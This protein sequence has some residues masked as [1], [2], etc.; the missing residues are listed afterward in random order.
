MINL[1]I[2][3]HSGGEYEVTVEEYDAVQVNADLNNNEINTV[4]FTNVILSRI[5]VKAVIPI[6]EAE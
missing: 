1:K 4:V 3:T 2:I 6:I 5:D